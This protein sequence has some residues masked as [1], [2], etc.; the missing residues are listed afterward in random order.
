[1]SAAATSG[2]RI[3]SLVLRGVGWKFVSQAVLQVSRIVIGVVLARLLTPH[4]Y[5]LAAMAL[6]FSSL[7][8]VFS[9]LALGAA[10]VQRRTLSER[11]RSTVFW[12]GLG[13]GLT[14]TL[15]GI[16][17]SWPLALAIGEPDVQPL[18]GAL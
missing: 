9:D 3:R 14:F 15:L 2:E 13:A 4:D 11:D 10:L 7:V 12:T 16:G 17:L 18:L 1:M 8:L 6:V 5:G